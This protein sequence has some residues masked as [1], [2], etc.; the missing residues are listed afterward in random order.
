MKQSKREEDIYLTHRLPSK[1]SDALS[2]PSIYESMLRLKLS[3]EL[4]VPTLACVVTGVAINPALDT[5]FLSNRGPLTLSRSSR[6]L[7]TAASTAADDDA[8]WKTC[9]ARSRRKPPT[10]GAASQDV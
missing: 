7:P 6:L 10:E 5:A 8:D 3:A 2:S 4:L 1:S 9:E